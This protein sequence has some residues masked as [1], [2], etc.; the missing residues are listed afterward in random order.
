MVLQAWDG[1]QSLLVISMRH[2]GDG[3]MP[4]VTAEGD[5]RTKITNVACTVL[6]T[7]DLSLYIH[8]FQFVAR[9]ST[10]CIRVCRMMYLPNRNFREFFV[11]R[12]RN[13]RLKKGIPGGPDCR[14]TNLFWRNVAMAD[15]EY[16]DNNLTSLLCMFASAMVII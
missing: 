8:C 5:L 13:L 9:L 10:Y 1:D 15:D 14:E 11:W 4:S 3:W 12:G 6:Q 2:M 7:T 16:C